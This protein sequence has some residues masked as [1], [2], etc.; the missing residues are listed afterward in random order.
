MK[1]NFFNV[2]HFT[3]DYRWSC[4]VKGTILTSVEISSRCERYIKL[5]DKYFFTLVKNII[6]VL[7]LSD[8]F[9]SDVKSL[10][11]LQ[12]GRMKA[13]IK[14]KKKIK[15]WNHNIYWSSIYSHICIHHLLKY[16]QIS[17]I[18]N[19]LIIDLFFIYLSSTTY[20]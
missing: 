15:M 6:D 13:S 9:K 4:V 7:F 17:K 19:V 16:K 10:F 20:I 2:L 8:R 5:N 12:M 18:S 1:N 14:V 11:Y 3:S